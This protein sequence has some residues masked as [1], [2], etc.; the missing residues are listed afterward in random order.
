M[1]AGLLLQDLGSKVWDIRVEGRGQTRQAGGVPWY[2]LLSR[3]HTGTARGLVI[4]PAASLGQLL[5]IPKP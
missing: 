1:Q 3:S 4:A 2:L 5:K